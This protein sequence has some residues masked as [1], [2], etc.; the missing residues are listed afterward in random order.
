MPWRTVTAP[1]RGL[2]DTLGTMVFMWV[3]KRQ[4]N[5]LI[6][7][8]NERRC[9]LGSAMGWKNLVPVPPM[10][11]PLPQPFFGDEEAPSD[12]QSS[13]SQWAWSL[14]SKYARRTSS[15][16]Q[17]V[18]FSEPEGLVPL[19]AEPASAS[20]PRPRSARAT[21]RNEA[22]AESVAS[23]AIDVSGIRS[24]AVGQ[25]LKHAQCGVEASFIV[26]GADR[27]GRPVLPVGLLESVIVVSLAGPSQIAHEL[28][29]LTDGSVRVTYAAAISGRYLLRVGV[30]AVSGAGTRIEPLPGSPFKLDITPSSPERA[31]TP[32]SSSSTTTPRNATTPRSTH[33]SPR[34]TP[35]SAWLSPES[36]GDSAGGRSA[37]GRSRS[38][39]ST[40]RSRSH[41]SNS[42][43]TSAVGA[44]NIRLRAP[45]GLM[46]NA[47]AGQP[48]RL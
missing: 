42:G 37:S 9:R 13:P 5:S 10:S 45:R 38:E 4:I 3:M 7:T 2:H 18:E 14:S 20:M 47:T 25:G 23:T 30:R 48:A 19:P 6:T 17:Q 16:P 22:L 12:P 11:T 21:E 24:T 41:H 27:S 33:S 8:R 44:A 34:G 31:R 28:E 26:Y 35:R 46:A 29:S 15:S 40:I 43:V 36:R 32:G 1:D 39:G